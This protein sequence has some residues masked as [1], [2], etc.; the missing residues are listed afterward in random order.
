MGK[1]L[2]V[3][4][5]L[6]I[7]F[8]KEKDFEFFYNTGIDFFNKKEYEKAIEYFKSAV[9]QKEVKPQAYYNLALS[10]QHISESDKSIATYLK[11]LSIMPE[12]YD[13]L[14]NLALIYYTQG[15]Y[16]KAVEFFTKCTQ[17]RKEEDGVKALALSYM[18][19]NKIQEALDLAEEL[20]N[21]P[22]IGTKLYCSVAKAFESKNSLNKDFSYIDKAIE[23]YSKALEQDSKN[24]D[25]Y[26]SISICYA[27]KGEWEQ[28]VEYCTK[29]L[30]VNPDSYDANNQMGLIYY[31]C[32]DIQKA[33][34]Y[35]EKALKLKPEGDYK[36]Y[37][38][39]AYAYEKFGDTDKAIKLFHQLIK[40]FPE[41]PAIDEIKNHLRILKTL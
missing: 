18:N 16:A 17:V 14:Y 19:L 8:L 20:F 37:S 36:V 30:E 23:M 41:I 32:N 33:V 10:Y 7:N 2:K 26:L 3:K 11:F 28:S 34:S 29:A 13:G 31:C 39:L 1:L 15:D 12:D 25:I 22:Q 9:E 40:K 4:E 5:Y 38:N 24:F 35:Y 21:L 27:K 6:N